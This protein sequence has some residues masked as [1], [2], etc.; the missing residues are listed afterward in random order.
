MTLNVN[1]FIENYKAGEG[2]QTL[3]CLIRKME[4]SKKLYESY[5]DNISLP[6]S[7][8]FASVE[9]IEKIIGFAI[10]LTKETNSV[11]TLNS[12]LKICDGILAHP[13]YEPSIIIKSQCE[14]LLDIVAIS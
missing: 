9:T 1:D 6:V 13:T 12:V 5:D 11:K 8:T 14:E 3:L 2:E 4:V 7:E 10:T